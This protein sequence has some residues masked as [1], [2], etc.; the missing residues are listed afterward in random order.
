MAGPSYGFVAIRA[1]MTEALRRRT[2]PTAVAP[3]HEDLVDH[4]CSVGHTK[5]QVFETIK[6]WMWDS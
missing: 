6:S 4:R 2:L 1:L 3:I 5:F